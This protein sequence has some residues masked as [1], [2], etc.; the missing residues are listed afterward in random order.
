MEREMRKKGRD[1]REGRREG[2][3]VE[4]RMGRERRKKGKDYRR[5]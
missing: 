5:K 2:K 3:R 4:E 1:A